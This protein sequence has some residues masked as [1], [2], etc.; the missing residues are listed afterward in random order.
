[1]LKFHHDFSLNESPAHLDLMSKA[2]EAVKEENES[3]QIG[4]YRLPRDTLSMVD[5]VKNSELYLDSS[6]EN[7]VVIGIGGSSLG[8]KAIM[9]MLPSKKTKP[10]YFL[11]NSDP[12]NISEIFSKIKK[13]NSAFI[14]ISKSGGTIETISIF[15]TALDYFKIDLE[16]EDSKRVVAITDSGSS[17]SKFADEYKIAQYNIPLNVGGRFSVLSAVGIVPLVLAGF[18]AA[19]IL[20]GA[21]EFLDSFFARKEDHLLRKALYYTQNSDSEKINV[22]FSYA[23]N[24]ENLSKWYVQLWGESLGKVTTS[25]KKVGLT[26]IG[27][28]GSTDQH[29]FLQLIMEGPRDKTV[30]F[31]NVEN[32]E[33]DLKIPDITLKHIEKTDFINGNSFNN[34]IN[35]QCDATKESLIQSGIS[36][37]SITYD[38]V[39]E[40]NIGSTIIYYELLTSISGVMLDINT[41]NQ[42]GVE[43]GKTILEKKF[44]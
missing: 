3:G 37:D 21:S 35:S 42:P 12:V 5:V 13:S 27:L 4:Y 14:V 8:I 28:I 26:P 25:G 33:N 24:M 1:M 18:N 2:Y 39:D 15:K 22:V 16:S 23:S 40:E 7:I 19:A 10:I 17:L 36:V 41:Y 34:L 6:I 20:N 11:E 38:K 31:I 32:F 9:Q 43:L 29:S 44:K 30:T